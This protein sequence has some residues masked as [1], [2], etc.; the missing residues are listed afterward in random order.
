MSTKAA[1]RA[2]VPA[3]ITALIVAAVPILVTL[4]LT[5]LGTGT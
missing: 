3:L 4:W 5:A 1:L 2:W